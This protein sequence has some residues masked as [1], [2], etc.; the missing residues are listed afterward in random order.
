MIK[1]FVHYTHLIIIKIICT[2]WCA[3]KIPYSY[4]A[5]V[6]SR[7]LSADL[8]GQLKTIMSAYL[9]IR[10]IWEYCFYSITGWHLL[11]LALSKLIHWLYNT[12][13]TLNASIIRN[14]G[15]RTDQKWK[16]NHVNNFGHNFVREFR[17]FSLFYHKNHEIYAFIIQVNFSPAKMSQY[18]RTILLTFYF[19]VYWF[20]ARIWRRMIINSNY[21]GL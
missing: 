19:K 17:R 5:Y 2:D 10:I 12:K 15:W 1:R 4:R 8:T 16:R 13:S 6:F 21:H 7:C 11:L 20:T 18:R 9:G 14:I 3:I